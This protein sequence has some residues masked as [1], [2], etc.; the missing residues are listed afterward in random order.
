MWTDEQLAEQGWSLEQIAQYRIEQDIAESPKENLIPEQ[1]TESQFTNS[2]HS[3]ADTSVS[4]SN[5]LQTEVLADSKLTS[6]TSMFQDKTQTILIVCMMII[7]PPLTLWRIHRRSR[8]TSWSK[9]RAR[10]KRN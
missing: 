10:R 5:N 4:A 9:W 1:V 2:E 7:A 3:E 8:R 6:T